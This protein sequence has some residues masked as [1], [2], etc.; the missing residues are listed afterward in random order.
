MKPT[1][2]IAWQRVGWVVLLAVLAIYAALSI[3]QNVLNTLWTPRAAQDL[4]S[5]WYA[6]H[7]VRQQQDPYRFA[8][9]A[10]EPV[11]PVH[12]LDG[13]VNLGPSVRQPGI[14]TV[15]PN[16]APYIMLLTPLAFLSWPYAKG[17]WLV[18]NLILMLVTP[19]L[20]WRLAHDY[21]MEIGKE[22]WFIVAL[23]FFSLFATRNAVGL[24]QTALLTF[25][26]MVTTLLWLERRASWSGL[27]LGLALSKYSFVLP[28]AMFLLWQ[29]KVR[30][31]A[32][33][34]AVQM[35]GAVALAAVVQISPLQVL[36]GYIDTFRETM[37]HSA[38]QHLGIHL[39]ALFP[40]NPLT[41]LSILVIGIFL[42]GCGW[43]LL[44]R[45]HGWQDP[46]GR[47]PAEFHV[48]TILALWSLLVVY[49]GTHDMVLILLWFAVAAY[50]VSDGARRPLPRSQMAIVIGVS[51]AAAIVLS[52]PN[53]LFLASP[54]AGDERW[55][56]LWRALPTL[57]LLLLL[58][59]AVWLF[60]VLY[61]RRSVAA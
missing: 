32:I 7:F 18:I 27:A 28:L 57:T 56:A 43:W 37:R 40:P 54:L 60:A 61:L 17:V 34:V 23:I 24:G 6:G 38:T 39:A 48:L 52:A 44:R 10:Q 29:R 58:T 19:L 5:V 31:L 25:V 47:G 59:T 36:I 50:A 46:Q 42:L 4:H 33:A 14:V 16:T 30:V 8:L 55:F 12:Y 35:I 21:G 13:A 51:A 11:F 20:V 2:R 22:V 53:S 15:A 45:Q 1:G 49:H 3:R 26:L 41:A 9:Q